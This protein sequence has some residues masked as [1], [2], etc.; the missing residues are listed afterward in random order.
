MTDL[1]SSKMGGAGV[2]EGL[3]KAA[4]GMRNLGWGPMHT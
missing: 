1:H 4:E 2:Q 3:T